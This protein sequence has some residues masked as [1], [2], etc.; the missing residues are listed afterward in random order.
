MQTRE[1]EFKVNLSLWT[2]IALAGYMFYGKVHINSYPSLF[3]YFIIAA[4]IYCMHIFLWMMP[5]QKSEDTDDHFIREY[6][7][8]VEQLINVSI[9]RPE[10]RI[11]YA[12]AKVDKLRKDGWSWIIAETGITLFLLIVLGIALYVG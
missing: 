1:I 8:N 9:N 10:A 2:L 12:W 5:I 3:L 4:S 6:R 7:T 11:G